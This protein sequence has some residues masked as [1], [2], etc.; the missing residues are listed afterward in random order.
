MNKTITICILSLFM[1]IGCEKMDADSD[2]Q[3][4]ESMTATTFTA[5]APSSTMD[6]RMGVAGAYTTNGIVFSWEIDDEVTLYDASGDAVGDF[7]VQSLN[8]DVATFGTDE[9]NL[10]L[11][12]GKTYTM[13]YPVSTEATLLH[14]QN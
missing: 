3:T 6:T 8:G 13:V 5:T 14:L 12:I 1:L 9:D 11:N 10:T 2:L 7:K 4:T